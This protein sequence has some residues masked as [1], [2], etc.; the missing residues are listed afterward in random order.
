MRGSKREPSPSLPADRSCRSRACRRRPRVCRRKE[1]RDDTAAARLRRPIQPL[2]R[3]RER[4]Q[5]RRTPANWSRG[6]DGPHPAS[7]PTRAA[8]RPI[9]HDRLRLAI[10]RATYPK[11]PGLL[12]ALQATPF[13]QSCRGHRLVRRRSSASRA[14]ALDRQTFQGQ[15]AC[16]CRRLVYGDEARRARGAAGF[17]RRAGP[18]SAFWDRESSRASGSSRSPPR[19]GLEIRAGRSNPAVIRTLQAFVHGP[20]TPSGGAHT[21]ADAGAPG[22]ARSDAGERCGPAAGRL[23][24]LCNG[25]SRE[26]R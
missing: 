19:R 25:F 23:P 21:G 1:R 3:P 11:L 7:A 20:C 15:R 10:D 26:A 12:S 2:Y 13:G 16:S 5:A 8:F 6:D 22:A 17:R 18:L 24:W 14:R 9:E 4:D